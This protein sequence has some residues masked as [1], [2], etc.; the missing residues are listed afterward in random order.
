M[1][2]PSCGNNIEDSAKFCKSCGAKTDAATAAPQTSPQQQYQQ[3]QHQ[4]Q[5]PQSQYQQPM[6]Q[7]ITTEGK[8]W[9]ITL[10]LC[11]FLGGLG[12][13]RFYAGHTTTGI[14]MLVTAGGCGIWV[15]IDIIMIV[16]GS[17]K[18]SDGRDLV[19]K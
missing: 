1:F 14:L 15:I 3:P 11:I 18:D 7:P 16:T 4:Y 19:K 9:L 13:H 8:D 2:C 5:Q 10:L 6:G 17:F 12:V